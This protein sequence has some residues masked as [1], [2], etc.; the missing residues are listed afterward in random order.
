MAL[1]TYT[2]PT[3]VALENTGNTFNVFTEIL[4][5][6]ADL[7]QDFEVKR[8]TLGLAG[9]IQKDISELPPSIHNL[10]PQFIQR[11]VELC[12]KSIFLKFKALQK[13]QIEQAED[14]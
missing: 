11:V 9:L 8:F 10:M 1:L 13:E 2:A 7:K 3:L 6:S 4:N 14:A 5:Q 12:D